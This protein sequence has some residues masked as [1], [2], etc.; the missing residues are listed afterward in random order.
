[1][2]SAESLTRP[3]GTPGA[4]APGRGGGLRA[5]L[6]AVRLGV[7]H[8]A[9]AGVLVLA[10]VLDIHRL[11]QNGYANIYYSAGVKSMLHSLHNFFFVSYDPGGLVT[12]D[13]PPLGL[14]VEAASGKLFGLSPLS[15]LLPEAV[16]GVLPVTALHFLPD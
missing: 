2:S 14:W 4:S 5:R 11:S 15:V 12:V 7:R 6:P 16:M 13:K 3:P 9:L 1:M 8:L 10:A